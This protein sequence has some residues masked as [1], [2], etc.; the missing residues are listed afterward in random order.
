MTAS[1]LEAPQD[2]LGARMLHIISNVNAGELIERNRFYR[3]GR[4]NRV[5][6]FFLYIP[7][8]CTV[9]QD[10]VVTFNN[11]Q[12]RSEMPHICNQ[13]LAQDCTSEHKFL[14]LLKRDL[15]LN[16]NDINV[17]VADL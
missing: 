2:N 14:V 1:Q 15:I 16:Q 10:T 13:V 11:K 5:T 3:P 4:I 17:L 8:K 12:Y 9:A 7:A 6:Q